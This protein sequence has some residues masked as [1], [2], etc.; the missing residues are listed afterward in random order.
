MEL[1]GIHLLIPIR[2][3]RYNI[4]WSLWWYL[5]T[6]RYPTGWG[7]DYFHVGISYSMWLSWPLVR[8]LQ[9]LLSLKQIRIFRGRAGTLQHTSAIGKTSKSRPLAR[10]F[11]ANKPWPMMTLAPTN[12]AINGRTQRSR[13]YHRKKGSARAGWCQRDDV[14]I[15]LYHKA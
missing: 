8:I 5:L 2:M 7:V 1:N 12:E 4:H 14:R 11:P 6:A 10:M 3:C 9:L 15:T 13:T